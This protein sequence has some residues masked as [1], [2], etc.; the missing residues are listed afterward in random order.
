MRACA[1]LQ[2]GAGLVSQLSNL[3]K[4]T[5]LHVASA[6]GALQVLPKLLEH[7]DI[8]HTDEVSNSTKVSMM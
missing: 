2:V 1:P 5:A 4:Q 6:A 3:Q 8:E 7:V